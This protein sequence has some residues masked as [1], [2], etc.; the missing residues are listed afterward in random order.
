MI[1]RPLCFAE[2]DAAIALA[3]AS[4]SSVFER[5]LCIASVDFA[6]SLAMVE[7]DDD[8]D[9]RDL[10]ADGAASAAF[11]NLLISRSFCFF[12]SVFSF[13]HFLYIATATATIVG[14]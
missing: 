13:F 1:V 4:A 10:D 11:C 8:D 2:P 6:R 9:G 5:S 12:R 14:K 7:F 3:C